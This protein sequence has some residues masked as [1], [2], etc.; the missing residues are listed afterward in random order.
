MLTPMNK[1]ADKLGG[2]AGKAVKSN[3]VDLSEVIE[4]NLSKTILKCEQDQIISSDTKKRL[5]DPKTGS[6]SERAISLVSEV[7]TVV[8]FCPEKLEPFLITVFNFD[9]RH[10]KL[11]AIKIANKCK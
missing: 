6:N 1:M 11:I 2:K 3:L 9:T 8:K 7:Q 5:S 10:S 4:S